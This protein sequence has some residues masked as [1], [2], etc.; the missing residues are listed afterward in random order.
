MGLL[1]FTG[2]LEGARAHAQ[3][4]TTQ[5]STAKLEALWYQLRPHF[6]F[7]L[8]NTLAYLIRTEPARARALT[9]DLADFLRYTLTTDTQ[10][11][12]L[13]QELVQIERYIELERAR[14]GDG[15]RFDIKDEC[16]HHTES[17]EVP[18]LILQPLV[19]NAIRH[20]AQD[21]KVSI[22]VHIHEEDDMLYVDI[23]DNGSGL[24]QPLD[25]LMR[26]ADVDP[27]RHQSV[28]LRNVQ[29]RLESFYQM[30]AHLELEDR[31]DR[32]GA[33]ARLVLPLVP[34]SPGDLNFTEKAQRRFRGV[35]LSSEER[36]ETP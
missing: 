16:S 21:A 20:G 32:P 3:K 1:N 24:R 27:K 17:F 33:R 18:P 2:E 12:A 31:A 25:V 6:L 29:E 35:I 11:T 22:V 13:R 34:V 10:Q 4:M 8:L 7:N 19:E 9:L 23:L 14:F 28:G 15:L 30:R 36:G 26:R 5:A